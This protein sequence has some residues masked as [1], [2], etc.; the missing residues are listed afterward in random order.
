MLKILF[1]NLIL[2]SILQGETV[3]EI[4]FTEKFLDGFN[5]KIDRVK[6]DQESVVLGADQNDYHFKM[7]FDDVNPGY[8]KLLSCSINATEFVETLF[9]DTP[10]TDEMISALENPKLYLLSKIHFVDTILDN[11]LSNK[12]FNR[13]LFIAQDDKYSTDLLP[14]NCGTYYPCSFKF[15]SI[16]LQQSCLSNETCT[17]DELIKNFKKFSFIEQHKQDRN[18]ITLGL[19]ENNLVIKKNLLIFIY[20]ENKSLQFIYTTILDLFYQYNSPLMELEFILVNKE[21]KNNVKLT[22]TIR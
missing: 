2:A 16:L 3:N 15:Y 13:L 1:I 6:P 14:L 8:S 17:S 11:Q 12:H 18:N 22:V 5:L 4:W 10:Q 21:V 20:I 7:Y 9:S 19:T